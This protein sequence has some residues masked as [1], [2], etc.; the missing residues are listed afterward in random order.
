[1]GQAM[2]SAEIEPIR[3]LIRFGHPANVRGIRDFPHPEAIDERVTAR[4]LG[5]SRAELRAIRTELEQVREEAVEQLLDDRTFRSDL[6]GVP[7][8]AGQ[9]VVALG[10]SLTADELSWAALLGS[11]A[12]R[13]W[14]G[15]APHIVNAGVSGDTT[16][17]VVERL[18]DIEALKPDWAVVLLLTNDS[19]REGGRNG[20]T[21]LSIRES[22]RNIALIER[23]L[24][25]HTGERI[26]WLTPPPVDEDTISGS[27]LGTQG[28]AWRNGDLTARATMLT[29]R[30]G[31]V[32]DLRALFAQSGGA[33][34]LE[35]D[36]LHLTVL[37]Q[38]LIVRHLVRGL[39]DAAGA[40]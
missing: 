3:R 21:A 19:R 20:A 39:V 5:I 34:L 9:T 14:R 13:L 16:L 11:A 7:W 33:G 37:A 2:G 10:D 17:H 27:Y 18:R 40:G 22:R 32:V 1:M 38:Q 35:D 30:A 6:L 15:R 8:T 31:F 36:G 12:V 29:D 23:R 28:L 26:V 24:A 4:L 25:V